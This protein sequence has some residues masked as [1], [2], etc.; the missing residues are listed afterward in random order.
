NFG[1]LIDERYPFCVIWLPWRDVHRQFSHHW[2]GLEANAP[3][4]A[5]EFPSQ[6]RRSSRLLHILEGTHAY[7]AHA[8]LP[9]GL[10]PALLRARF[11]TCSRSAFGASILPFQQ[12]T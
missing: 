2:R 11:P 6:R 12:V 10:L 4:E 8:R 7:L 1:A 5:P 3:A 9:N